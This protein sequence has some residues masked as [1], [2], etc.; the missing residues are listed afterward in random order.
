MIFVRAGPPQG[1]LEH[2]PEKWVRFSD[3]NMPQRIEAA[4]ILVTRVIPPK[5][6]TR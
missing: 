4:R 6:N 5:W 3:E 2:V 1:C